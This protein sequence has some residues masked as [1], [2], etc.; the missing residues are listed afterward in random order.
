M[1]IKTNTFTIFPIN[2]VENI[3]KHFEWMYDWI[4]PAHC[5][6]KPVADEAKIIELIKCKP[7]S[8]EATLKEIDE[9]GFEPVPSNY[10]LGLGVQNPEAHKEYKY[11]V[12]LDKNNL[13]AS[14]FG[15]PCFL[16]LRWNDGR[17]LYM[18][19]ESGDW[20]D[21]W[22]FAVVRKGT[23]DSL[24]SDPLPLGILETLT[25]RV[26]R[27]EKFVEGIKTLCLPEL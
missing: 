5:P 13:F 12:S 17:E 15:D 20:G 18:A 6:I 3:S 7:G 26:E 11:V 14:K 8:T 2:S 23:S 21:H 19:H 24:K 10:V 16:C 27:L 9:R 1:K 25:A 4:T 22:W